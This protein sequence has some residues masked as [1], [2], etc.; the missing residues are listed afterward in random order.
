M[1]TL[2]DKILDGPQIHYCDADNDDIRYDEQ[3]ARASEMEKH[4]ISDLIR[5]P[6]DD[7]PTPTQVSRNAMNT[8]PKGVLEDF[9][10][11]SIPSNPSNRP[12]GEVKDDIDLEF[13]QLMNDE[14]LIKDYV[15]KRIAEAKSVTLKYFGYVYHLKCGDDLLDAI[16]NESPTVLVIVHIYTKYSKPCAELNR[17]LHRLADKYKQI[18]FCTLDASVT[19]LSVNFKKNG[20]PAILAYKSGDLVKSL[21]QL[22]E[23]LDKHFEVEQV[24]ELLIDNELI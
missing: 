1:S 16:E 24:E 9:K 11:L 14:D 19:G 3:D 2:E 23:F 20:V 8:G 17:C 6:S 12:S 10:K 18:K 13:Q 5:P 15:S 4:S 22:D 21:V 7:E